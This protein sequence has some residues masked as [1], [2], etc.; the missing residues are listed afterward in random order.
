MSKLSLSVEPGYVSIAAHKRAKKAT[1]RAHVTGVR[2]QLFPKDHAPRCACCLG[3][4]AESM[5]EIRSAGAVGS[6]VKA[7]S[8]DNSIPVCGSGTTKCHGYLQHHRILVRVLDDGTRVYEA[9]PRNR[10]DAPA[11]WLESG[12]AM[13]DKACAATS[14]PTHRMAVGL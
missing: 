13:F 2:G 4:R 5:H 9:N 6:R 1:R 3:R 12:W 8:L 14:G 7:V 11:K 10:N